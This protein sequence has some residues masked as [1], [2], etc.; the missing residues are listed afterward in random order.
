MVRRAERGRLHRDTGRGRWPEQRFRADRVSRGERPVGRA[1]IGALGGRRAGEDHGEKPP[2][3]GGEPDDRRDAGRP[4]L[5][6][7][8]RVGRDH[9]VHRFADGANR[10]ACRRR[11]GR[12]V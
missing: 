12:G 4:V 8:D 5:R 7:P 9:R 3:P 10:R 11:G 6:V 2:N 1:A